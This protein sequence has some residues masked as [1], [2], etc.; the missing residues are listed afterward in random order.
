VKR[1]A[2]LM[3]V[4]ALL[5][6]A[7]CSAIVGFPDVPDIEDGG[8]DAT[9][10][11]SSG[12]PG[13]S[14]TG[15]SSGAGDARYTGSSSSSGSSGGGGV[16]DAASGSGGGDAAEASIS[17]SGGADGGDATTSSSSSSSGGSSSSGSSSGSGSSSSSSGS[18][19]SSSGGS[20]GSCNALA[21]AAPAVTVE[22]VAGDP[23]ATLGGSIA[24]GTYFLTNFTNY[25]G[26]VTGSSGS[27]QTTIQI[28]AGTIQVVTS[29]TPTT[30]TETLSTSGSNFTT[31]DTCPDTAV[32]Q[33]SYTATS[34]TLILQ[35]VPGAGTNDASDF[36]SQETFTMQSSDVGCTTLNVYN[37]DSWCVVS[38][39]GGT[40]STASSQSVC[41]APGSTPLVASPKDSTFELG[42][43]PWVYISGTGG[44]DSGIA[45]TVVG[46]GGVGS[47]S[48][49]TVVV[50]ST[51]GCVLVCCPFTNGTGC[52]SA[53]SGFTTFTENCP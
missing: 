50:G 48:S 24:S 35:Y 11:D 21:N 10:P 3:A 12:T 28:N 44:T 40:S 4:A 15:S 23:P 47:T 29:G 52:N 2:V 39:N 27:V 41:V 37:F 5:A 9:S 7:A 53:F 6:P 49:T 33:G 26:S 42:P 16:E 14:G 36:T 46:D 30:R 18:S 22:Q 31:T 19:S 25:T 34:T 20:S 32:I 43:D 13:S 1:F 17:S 51:P 45:G 38:V 8:E